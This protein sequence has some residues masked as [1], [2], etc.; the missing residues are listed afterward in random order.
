VAAVPVDPLHD[1]RARCD[2]IEEAY[3]FFLAY[4]SQGLPSDAGTASGSEIR[5]QLRK[6]ADAMD[7]LGAVLTRAVEQ[8]PFGSPAP[9]DTFIGVIDRDAKD[10][11]AAVRMVLA[12]RVDVNTPAADGMTALHWAVQNNDAAIVEALLNG[13]SPDARAFVRRD[14]PASPA[15]FEAERAVA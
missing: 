15:P 4:A 14:R 11:Q 7:G 12:Q 3:E 9:F 8:L 5:A 6:C 10:A 13:L 1:F 2:T